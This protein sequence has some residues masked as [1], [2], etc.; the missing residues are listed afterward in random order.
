VALLEDK[1]VLVNGGTQGVGAAIV[2][3]ARREGARVTFTGRR[4]AAGE[5]DDWRAEA[6]RH[7]PVILEEARQA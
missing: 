4:R 5:G 1:V 7:R 2:R 6:A 3:A